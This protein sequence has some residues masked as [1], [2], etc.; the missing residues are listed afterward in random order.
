[1]RIPIFLA[2]QNLLNSPIYLLLQLFTYPLAH[3][4]ISRCYHKPRSVKDQISQETRSTLHLT[5][6]LISLLTPNYTLPNFLAVN[7]KSH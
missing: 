1:M 7:E 6:I 4:S 3:F 2:E 5:P